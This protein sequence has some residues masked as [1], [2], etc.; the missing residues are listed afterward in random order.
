M[1]SFLFLFLF[2]SFLYFLSL[3]FLN[4]K[5]SNDTWFFKQIEKPK[6]KRFVQRIN[7]DLK[8]RFKKKEGKRRKIE[9]HKDTRLKI[10]YLLKQDRVMENHENIRIFRALYIHTYIH[11]QV[12]TY[13]LCL[14]FYADRWTKKYWCRYLQNFNHIPNAYPSVVTNLMLII[15]NIVNNLFFLC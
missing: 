13:I 3:V 9:N 14:T 11:S 6:R 12:L 4:F 8:K 1:F 15:K 7:F 5:L 10:A 2:F